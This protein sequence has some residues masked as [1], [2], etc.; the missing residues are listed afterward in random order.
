MSCHP[1]RKHAAAL[2]MRWG[3]ALLLGAGAQAAL[4][5]DKASAPTAAHPSGSESCPTSLRVAFLDKA[6]PGMLNGD[7]DAFANPPGPFVEWLDLAMQ[8]LGCRATKVRVPQMRL[9]LDTADDVNQITF[10]FAHTPERAQQL[11]YP[12]RLNGDLDTNMALAE[13]R[14]ALFVRQDRR[15]QVQWDGKE[16]SPSHLRVGVVGGGVEERLAVAAGWRLD[17]ALSHASSIVKLRVGRVDVALLPT[18]SFSEQSLATAPALVALEP[19]LQR[20]HFFAP[21]SPG[22][23]ARNDAFVKRFWRT[24][25][26]VA[27][28]RAHTQGPAPSCRPS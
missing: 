17:R 16:L 24:L 10:Y 12:Q 15:D 22:L 28:G 20:I 21:V 2:A 5:G 13:S 8:R 14:L 7:G 6:I 3:L 11:M 1:A 9:L 23:M 19:P 26:E 18:L 27:R 4:A 25:C